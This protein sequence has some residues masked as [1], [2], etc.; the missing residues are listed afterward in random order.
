[1]IFAALRRLQPDEMIENE[2]IAESRRVGSGRVGSGRIES[3][4][5]ESNR[6]ESSRIESADSLARRLAFKL[7]TSKIAYAIRQRTER[8]GFGT[9]RYP[10]LR[11]DEQ[12]SERTNDRIPGL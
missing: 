9:G 11:K 7:I 12:A 5:V 4:R 3:N 6:I 10:D 2:T 1:M 8:S